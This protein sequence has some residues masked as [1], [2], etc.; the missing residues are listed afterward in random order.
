MTDFA[1]LLD[2]C[3]KLYYRKHSGLL[4]WLG[5]RKTP[6]YHLRDSVRAE[7]RP[8]YQ[9]LLEKGFVVWGATAQV[10]GGMFSPGQDDLPGITVYSDDSHFDDHPEDLIDIAKALFALKGTDP[11]DQELQPVAAGITN[12]YDNT[13]RRLLPD[14]LTD[15]RSVYMA[16]TIF[17]R[18]RIPGGVVA[19]RILPLVIAPQLTEVS[20]IL[21][22]SY[23]PGSLRDNWREF[24]EN[25]ELHPSSSTAHQVALA[26]EKEPFVPPSLRDSDTPV[27]ITLLAA[28][29]IWT[30]IG[31]PPNDEV[32]PFLF[33]GIHTN[34]ENIGKKYACVTTGF[35]PRIERCFKSNGVYVV[36]RRDQLDQMRGAIVGYQCSVFG[37]GLTIALP[38]E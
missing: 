22:S 34:G 16:Y 10:N 12:E 2:A 14:K 33:I 27:H 30:A 13:P 6:A 19:A 4:G 36:I 21:P 37:T 20:M 24:G 29:S 7:L 18:H 31:Q 3:R 26:A 15:G 11:S 23:W 9:L 1:R 35:D 38:G 8:H 25:C 32:L 5:I 28:S 17:H